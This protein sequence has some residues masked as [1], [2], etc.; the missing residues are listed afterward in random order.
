MADQILTQEQVLAQLKTRGFETGGFRSPLR[1]FRG[2]L[3]SITGAMV[4]R[5]QM[6]QPRLE[7]SYNFSDVEVFESTE[8][9]PFPVAQ[10]SLMHST[11]KQSAMGVL[12]DS[13]DKIL[14]ADLD[15]N[16]PQEKAKNQDA[17][18]NV[19]QEWKVTP[20]HMMPDRDE[21]GKWTEAPRECW[22]VVYAEGYGGTP[23]SGVAVEEPAEELAQALAKGKAAPKPAGETPTQRAISLLDGKTQQQWNNTVFQDAMVKGD[24]QLV[25]S[26]I[27]GQFLG[28]LEEAGVVTKDAD[29]IYHKVA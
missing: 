17:L 12:G 6:P 14:N 13:M 18:I 15:E 27:T 19:V 7:V 16:A 8:P 4:Q 2:K 29:G 22:E 21:Q 25:N 20:G 26:I 28:P 3:D 11:R 24:P 10:V 1:H 23:H 5:G 9:Y